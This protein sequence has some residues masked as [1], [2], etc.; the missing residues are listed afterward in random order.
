M[1]PGNDNKQMTE[2]VGIVISEVLMVISHVVNALRK[3]PGFDPESFDA[4]LRKVAESEDTSALQKH[5][6]ALLLANQP[7]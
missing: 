4:E 2:A 3:Q 6:M 7:K 5:A 1:E